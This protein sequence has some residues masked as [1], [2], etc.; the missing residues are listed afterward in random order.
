MNGG[1]FQQFP[2]QMLD[3]I[4]NRFLQLQRNLLHN[5]RI[6]RAHQFHAKFVNSFFH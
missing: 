6:I 5:L 4:V 3:V 1:N 2:S